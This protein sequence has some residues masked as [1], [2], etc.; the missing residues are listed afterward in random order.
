[1]SLAEHKQRLM[2]EGRCINCLS[3]VHSQ[4]HCRNQIRC[5]LST[6]IGHTTKT[7][8]L[9]I[10]RIHKKQIIHQQTINKPTQQQPKPHQPKQNNT[11][12]KPKPT[13]NPPNRTKH[14]QNM[15]NIEDWEVTP[16]NDAQPYKSQRPN[17]RCIFLQ[18]TELKVLVL[19]RAAIV[20]LG[21]HADDPSLAQTLR[22]HLA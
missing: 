13:H 2:T 16:M 5:L 17:Q 18:P 6:S 14:F 21:R 15:A 22:Y 9:N 11:N 1:M 8:A 12:L 7:C 19:H 20:R 10:K 3:K 4:K